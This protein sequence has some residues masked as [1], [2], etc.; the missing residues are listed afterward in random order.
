MY[1]IIYTLYGLV[2]QIS[3]MDG[4]VF[5]SGLLQDWCLCALHK[6]FGSDVL[7]NIIYI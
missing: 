2:F 1:N 3:I 4:C 5:Q 6:Q 7:N